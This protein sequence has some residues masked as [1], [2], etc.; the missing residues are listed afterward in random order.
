[1]RWVL[2]SF[3]CVYYSVHTSCE[4][5][6]ILLSDGT[7]SELWTSL[8][9]QVAIITKQF[10]YASHVIKRSKYSD[11]LEQ[12]Y[13]NTFDGVLLLCTFCNIK[14][15]VKVCLE[16]NKYYNTFFSSQPESILNCRPI[17]RNHWQVYFTFLMFSYV[18][19]YK[20]TS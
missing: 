11:C 19:T 8:C 12:I 1:M 2:N 14:I 3:L 17:R 9:V 15:Q 10:Y 13:F 18:Q 6:N 20:N 7:T 16:H 4:C 5:L